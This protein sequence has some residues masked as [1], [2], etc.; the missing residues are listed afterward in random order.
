MLA[1]PG[2][3]GHRV[4]V[5]RVGEGGKEKEERERRVKG[6]RREGGVFC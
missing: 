3:Y 6:A 4:Q 1:V 2:N 5:Y